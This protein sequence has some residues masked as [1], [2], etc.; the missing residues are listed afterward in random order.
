M[1]VIGFSSAVIFFQEMHL[2][3]PCVGRTRNKRLLSVFKCHSGI[4]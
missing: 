4:Q 2:W 1:C 3:P